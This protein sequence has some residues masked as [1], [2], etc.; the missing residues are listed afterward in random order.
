MLDELPGDFDFRA[1]YAGVQA[2]L[3][4]ASTRAEPVKRY[5]E[6]IGPRVVVR[7][8]LSLASV[9]RAKWRDIVNEEARA[10]D[11]TLQEILSRRRQASLVAVRRRICWRIKNET[12][13]SY[14]QIGRVLNRD[15]TSILHH[16][17]KYQR[18]ID[19]GRAQP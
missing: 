18:M 3:K 15:H 12:M 17:H 6:P 7:D 11:V 13:M 5:E 4:A 2:R 16:V 14:P 10:G 19:E 9:R 8:V 1:H